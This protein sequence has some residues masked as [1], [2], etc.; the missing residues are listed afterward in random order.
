[1]TADFA[2]SPVMHWAW[3]TFAPALTALR[4]RLPD[5]T[6]MKSVHSR[7]TY[8]VSELVP[9]DVAVRFDVMEA[10]RLLAVDAQGLQCWDRVLKATFPISAETAARLFGIWHLALPGFE[11]EHYSLTLFMEEIVGRSPDLHV[12]EVEK[13]RWPLV[14]EGC[15]AELAQVAVNGVPMETFALEHA[16]EA[17]VLRALDALELPYGPN[18][19]YPQA[20][21]EM[22]GIAALP[23]A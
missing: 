5:T 20:I 3:R 6:G 23:P 2:A 15:A 4:K 13:T 16:E 18:I 10:R 7:E 21:K 1:M 9:H 14:Y 22:L 12:A 19:S 8:I 11:R 17:V